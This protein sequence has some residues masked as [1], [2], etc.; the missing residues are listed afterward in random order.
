MWSAKF[1]FVAHTG[2]S[3]PKIAENVEKTGFGYFVPKPSE[4]AAFEVIVAAL[5]EM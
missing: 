3:D 4:P 2:S 5:R 1:T